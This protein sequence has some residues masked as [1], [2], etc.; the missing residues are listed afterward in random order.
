MNGLF[1][2]GSCAC[3]YH[4]AGVLDGNE[5]LSSVYGGL[6]AGRSAVN[7]TA[8]S[9]VPASLIERSVKDEED[10]IA[11]MMSR[12]DVGVNAHTITRELGEMLLDKAAIAKDDEGLLEAAGYI[13]EMEDRAK[14]MRPL[15][16][17]QWANDEISAVRNVQR[18][19]V[20]ARL[21][22]EASRNRCES[23]GAHYKPATPDRDDEKWRVTTKASYGQDVP[24]FDY[25]EQIVDVIGE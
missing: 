3:R 17:A 23:R 20:L 4:G 22:V 8:S 16:G 2:A 6:I 13:V 18:E 11:K 25:S 12:E 7:K 5:I 1:A 10:S 19:L 24:S 21:I 15:D 9:E 14:T